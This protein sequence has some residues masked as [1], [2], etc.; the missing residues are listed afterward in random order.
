MKRNYDLSTFY[1][2]LAKWYK[3]WAEL[4][5][6]ARA[7]G[8]PEPTIP[9]GKANTEELPTVRTVR[10]QGTVGRKRG[11]PRQIVRAIE[12][13]EN[14]KPQGETTVPVSELSRPEV[15]LALLRRYGPL[16]TD[17]LVR[18]AA[19]LGHDWS[20]VAGGSSNAVHGSL[21]RERKRGRVDKAENGPWKLLNES[22]APKLS[23]D[24]KTAVVVSLNL[25]RIADQ[26]RATLLDIFGPGRQKPDDLL[27]QM[28]RT[29]K[30]KSMTRSSLRD[31]LNGLIAEGK[32]VK[33]D[34]GEYRKV[35]NLTL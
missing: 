20:D 33:T 3:Q 8:V 13:G 5:A 29:D 2:A 21:W 27:Q 22:I 12:P 31:D 28:R 4:Q 24:G 32:I 35:P 14:G 19:A 15:C 11:R 18:E 26:R 23:Q 1:E 30:Y 17:K 10:V 7:L 34:Y 9:G 25:K 6:W 16:D